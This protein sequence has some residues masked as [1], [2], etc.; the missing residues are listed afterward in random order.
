MSGVGL[1]RPVH[2]MSLDEATPD[3]PPL[4]VEE[5]TDVFHD[6]PGLS[7]E[8]PRVVW[9]SP[10]PMSTSGRVRVADFEVFV[11]RHHREVR[12]DTRLRVEHHFSDHLRSRGLS[13]PRVHRGENGVSVHTRG[14]YLYEVFDL[15][16]GEDRY[17][18]V[19]SWLSYLSPADA[20][21]A[22]VALASFH[23]AS[24]DFDEPATPWSV[25]SDSVEL[26]TSSSLSETL[27]RL[28]SDR[29]GLALGL[30]E[31]PYLDDASDVLE[32][33]LARARELTVDEAP[34]WTHGD[35][36]PSNLTWSES[37]DVAS[38][39][40]L[41]LANRTFALRDLALAI[42]RAVVDWLDSARRGVIDFDEPALRALLSGYHSRRPL[43]RADREALSVL[44]PV[45]HV[46]FALSEVEY[47]AAVTGSL[48]NRDL[49]YRN[50]LLGHVQWF[51]TTPGRRLLDL[52]RHPDL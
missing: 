6:L 46:E 43:S 15:A 16:L 47:F 23:A 36:H 35:W 30:S 11:K 37:G 3:W 5:L 49:A 9:H 8:E 24:A 20:A 21:Q 32:G 22:G 10:R 29:P 44:L 4:S 2:G 17:A 51:T 1:A 14:E 19:A 26:L 25:L 31:Y 42:E 13:T 39:I 52:V 18:D 28:V 38:V 7:H 45:V 34:L 50:Y 27:A 12:N 48:V 41:S 33:P 40:D